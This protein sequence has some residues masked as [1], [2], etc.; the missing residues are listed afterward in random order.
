MTTSTTELRRIPLTELH[1]SPHNPRSR[2]DPTELKEMADSLR[3]SGQLTPLLVRPHPNGQGGYELAAG[4]CR[5]RAAVLAE[6]THLDAVVRELDDATFVQFVNTENRQRNNLHPL[7]EARGFV[8]WMKTAGLDIAEI[9]ERIGLSTK[10]VYDRVKLLQ[11]TKPAQKSFLQGQFTAGHAILLARL[12]KDDQARALG[13]DRS[14]NGQIGGLF[15]AEHGLVDPRESLTES[16]DLD[17][18]RKPVSVRE[19]QGWIDRNVRFKPEE[20]DLPNLFPETATALQHAAETEETIVKIT[21][22]WRVPDEAKDEKDRTYGSA[23]WKRA[24]G[25]PERDWGGKQVGG[26][27]CEHAVLGVVVAGPGRGEAFKVCL[28]K[29]KCAVHWA[30]EQ[31]ESAKRSTSSAGAP[32][33]GSEARHEEQ[34]KREHEELEAERARFKKALPELIRAVVEKLVAAPADMDGPLGA[35]LLAHQRFEGSSK[36][37]FVPKGKGAEDLVRL[38]AWYEVRREAL[39]EWRGPSEAPRVL[40]TLGIDV[41]KI[42]DQVAPKPE[43]AKAE[44]AKL[45]PSAK[46]QGKP[47]DEKTAK[48]EGCGC[49]WKKPCKGGCAW[50]PNQWKKGRAVC[51]ACVAKLAKK[52]KPKKKKLAG[53]VRRAQKKAKA[54]T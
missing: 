34:R 18:A 46:P 22:E 33:A 47:L 43:P 2:F 45:Q 23:M 7:D 39:N 11:L 29:K 10:Y 27:P 54:K 13:S 26:K 51:T 37:G 3:A 20:V 32:R 8:D 36:G 12:S 44:K 30:A 52:P 5:L 25:T 41:R 21:R 15:V 6:F 14:G 17:D 53:D 49:T 19:F 42:V 40:K 50:S 38:L 9:A 4:A 35:L 24:D 1:E 48:C 16:L 31:R 28:E